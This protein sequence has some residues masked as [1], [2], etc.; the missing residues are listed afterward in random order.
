M[1][2]DLEEEY[3]MPPS[4]SPFADNP[5]KPKREV[6][7]RGRFRA[8]SSMSHAPE[9]EVMVAVDADMNFEVQEEEAPLGNT[10]SDG[11]KRIPFGQKQAKLYYV[12]RPGFMRRWVNDAPGRMMGAEKG[13]Y[14]NVKDSNGKPVSTHAGTQSMGGAL[15]AYLMEIPQQW[16]DED[17]AFKQESVD[18]V[19]KAIYGGTFK[20]ES[21]D[22][23][24]VP[25]DTPIKFGLS[26]GSG[27]G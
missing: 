26:R 16:Y 2:H 20:E 15:L 13:G 1:T 22:K 10:L 9:A 4:T 11:S 17:F 8:S 27:K 14:T 23:R 24:Y 5:P 7:K 18:E 21:D 25:K 3:V 19:D 12:S 6:D